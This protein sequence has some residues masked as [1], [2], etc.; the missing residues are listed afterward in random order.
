MNVFLA[1]LTYFGYVFV[2]AMY[3]VKAVKYPSFAQT[4][5][6]GALPGHTRREVPLRRVLLRGPELDRARSPKGMA[7]EHP[8]PPQGVFYPRRILQAAQ[9]LLAGPL[10]VAYRFHPDHQL[11][12]LYV[13]CRPGHGP[14]PSR[15]G[16][17]AN[18]GGKGIL[19]RCPS[20]GH[21]GLYQRCCW[22][23]SGS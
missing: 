13:L 6:V 7:Q 15:I 11:S 5:A 23:A 16:R 21:C 10:P 22:E 14:R 8:V 20:G 1:V 9:R 4:L 17:L 12:H 2:T 19:L 3:T 18:S